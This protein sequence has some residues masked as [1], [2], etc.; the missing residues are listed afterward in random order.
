METMNDTPE[1]DANAE[2]DQE[3]GSP[4]APVREWVH[5]DFAR[6]LERE[7]D[8]ARTEL[9]LWWDGNILHE[10]HRD[11]LE[12]A[13]RE[14]DEAREQVQQLNNQ[15]ARSQEAATI[16]YRRCLGEDAEWNLGELTKLT[17]E[18]DELRDMLQEE[19]RLHIQTL[20]ERDEA[21]GALASRLELY[22]FQNQLLKKRSKDKWDAIDQ[23]DR[24]A[25]ALNAILNDDPDSPLYKIKEARAALAAWKEARSES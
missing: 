14:R 9:E 22:Q 18:R 5:A 1:T 21:R 20:N 15:I 24:L 17:E 10:I 23:R 11:E 2:C 8:E 6:K 12:K 3:D 19:Q 13:E 7:R 16:W 4:F 25:E